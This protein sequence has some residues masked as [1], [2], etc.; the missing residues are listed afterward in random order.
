MVIT[1]SERRLSEL[2]RQLEGIADSDSEIAFR[3]QHFASRIF[4]HV[5]DCFWSSLYCHDGFMG[6]LRAHPSTPERCR[7]SAR[8]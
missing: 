4:K 8:R 5:A 2:I 1:L 7:D 6:P 3:M